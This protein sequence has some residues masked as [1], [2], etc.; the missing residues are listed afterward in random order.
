MW[1]YLFVGGLI[2]EAWEIGLKGSKRR[3]GFIVVSFNGFMTL[4]SLS[5]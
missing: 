3:R 1:L 2:G 4:E 5:I